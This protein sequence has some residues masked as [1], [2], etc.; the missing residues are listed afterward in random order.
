MV[1]F[2]NSLKYVSNLNLV[3]NKFIWRHSEPKIYVLV[4]TKAIMYA[5]RIPTKLVS[6]L[7]IWKWDLTLSPLKHKW[8]SSFQL[9]VA[10][11]CNLSPE[12][13]WQLVQH[14]AAQWWP[15]YRGHHYYGASCLG[16]LGKEI[17]E[18]VCTFFFPVLQIICSMANWNTFTPSF[19]NNW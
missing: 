8:L 10:Q 2:T 1:K 16:C 9:K 7:G 12:L 6:L 15:S 19:F 18:N 13:E 3:L 11:F 14:P 17:S 4:D 5:C